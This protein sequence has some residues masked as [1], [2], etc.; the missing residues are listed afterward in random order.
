MVGQDLSVVQIL[1]KIISV[2]PPYKC[3]SV[4]IETCSVAADWTEGRRE[5][6]LSPSHI[7]EEYVHSK[8]YFNWKMFL[9][10]NSKKKENPNEGWVHLQQ[11]TQ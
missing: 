5:K 8:F 11:N 9:V 2:F 3:G 6:Q 4:R 1:M 7:A 10:L